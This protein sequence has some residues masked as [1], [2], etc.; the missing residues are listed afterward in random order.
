M[1]GFEPF[2]CHIIG[3]YAYILRIYFVWCWKDFNVSISVLCATPPES[4]RFH[5]LH[6]FPMCDAIYM[7]NME[8]CMGVWYARH[9]ENRPQTHEFSYYRCL[10]VSIYILHLW[11]I[12]PSTYIYLYTYQEGEILSA[13]LL[14]AVVFI[15]F[16]YMYLLIYVALFIY[17]SLY[18][19]NK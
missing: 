6:S 11:N 5:T 1:A 8:V 9:I 2:H 14:H 17:S 16:L 18:I 15:W 3:I 4:A 19:V 12:L 13:F 10:C 7:S